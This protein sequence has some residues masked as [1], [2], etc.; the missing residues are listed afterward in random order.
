MRNNRDRY[1]RVYIFLIRRQKQENNNWNRKCQNFDPNAR[2]LT[3]LKPD[4][5]FNDFAKSWDP[6]NKIDP[7]F[8]YF[9]D[10]D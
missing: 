3:K 8:F 1:G 9:K 4:E 5:I 7:Y 6:I 2:R 10:M